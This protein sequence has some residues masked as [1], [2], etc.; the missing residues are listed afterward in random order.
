MLL[1]SA[2]HTELVQ[3]HMGSIQISYRNVPRLPNHGPLHSPFPSSMV[4]CPSLV[5]SDAIQGATGVCGAAGL[6]GAAGGL[7][8]ISLS[9]SR[10]LRDTA[11][12][13]APGGLSAIS[14]TSFN[15]RT[16]LIRDARDWI[17]IVVGPSKRR[18]SWTG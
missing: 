18:N 4:A 3:S 11:S 1:Q 13:T 9:S 5:A 16:S 17:S 2:K 12:W 15:V 14:S 8:A 10:I 6:C 7:E